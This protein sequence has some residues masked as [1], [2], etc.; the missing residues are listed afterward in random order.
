MI[1]LGREP[2][3]L[4]VNIRASGRPGRETMDDECMSELIRAHRNPAARRLHGEFSQ[5]APKRI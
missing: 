2:W 4:G 3:Q 5:K 1:K